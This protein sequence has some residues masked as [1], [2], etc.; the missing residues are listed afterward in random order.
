MWSLTTCAHKKKKLNVIWEN[1]EK[2]NT[3]SLWQAILLSVLCIGFLNASSIIFIYLLV[4][5]KL[6]I[7]GSKYLIW[8]WVSETSHTLTPALIKSGHG[9]RHIGENEES[10]LHRKRLIFKSN[11]Q[12]NF[13]YFLERSVQ[14]MAKV[15]KKGI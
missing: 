6:Q 14:I 4:Q 7:S 11:A 5:T 10:M 3:L 12:N 8:V 2:L 13:I 15:S 1:K 9:Y